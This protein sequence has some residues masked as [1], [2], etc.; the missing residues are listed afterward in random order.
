MP[1]AYNLKARIDDFNAKPPT[2]QALI[3]DQMKAFF[4]LHTLTPCAFYISRFDVR[5]YERFSTYERER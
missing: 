3:F 4:N 5:A 2:V 1:P